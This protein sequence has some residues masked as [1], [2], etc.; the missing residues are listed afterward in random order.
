MCI[1]SLSVEELVAQCLQHLSDLA[2][3]AGGGG[4]C[5]GCSSG[6]GCSFSIALCSRLRGLLLEGV[7]LGFFFLTGV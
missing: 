4:G 3:F 5:A 6:P 2:Q 1:L 7:A